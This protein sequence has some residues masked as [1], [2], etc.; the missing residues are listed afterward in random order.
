MCNAAH[1]YADALDTEGQAAYE[2]CG[3]CHEYDGNPRM[4]HTPV[5]AG[6]WPA[7]MKKQL[8]DYRAGKR[9]GDM[10]ATAEVISDKDIDAAVKYFSQQQPRQGSS[11][12]ISATDVVIARKLFIQG[13]AR[14]GTIACLNCHG[15][16]SIQEEVC[17]PGGPRDPG[18]RRG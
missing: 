17:R 11:D 14:R 13:D 5:I 9:H 6:Q 16:P 10:D 7:Y 3:L 18:R 2:P 4:S 12:D 15:A 8:Q 1:S